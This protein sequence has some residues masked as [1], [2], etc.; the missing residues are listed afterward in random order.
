[1][2][3][4]EKL[5]RGLREAMVRAR[6][7]CADPIQASVPSVEYEIGRRIGCAQGMQ[8]ALQVLEAFARDDDEREAI[9]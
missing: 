3:G 6:L 7:A 9:L 4:L 2:R 5:D 1:V 8:L